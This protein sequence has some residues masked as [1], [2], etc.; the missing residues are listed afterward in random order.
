MTIRFQLLSKENK[1]VP[2]YI[3]FRV[4][5]SKEL[6]ARTGLYV[7]PKDWNDKKRRAFSRNPLLKNLN[8]DLDQIA[9]NVLRNTPKSKIELEDLLRGKSVLRTGVV[10]LLNEMIEET[11]KNKWKHSTLRNYKVFYNLLKEYNGFSTFDKID[12]SKIDAFVSWLLNTKKYSK[13]YSG[14]QLTRLK[15]ICREARILGISTHPYCTDFKSFNQPKS[16]R[17]I[18]TLSHDEVNSLIE[19]SLENKRLE[20][21][22]KWLVLGLHLGFRVNDLLKTTKRNYRHLNDLIVCD[23]IQQKTGNPVTVPILNK[24]VLEI[25]D[26]YPKPIT[27]V[28]FNRTIKKVCKFAG[29]T[30]EIVGDL[31]NNKT[32]RKERGVYPKYKLISSH[33]MRRTFAT[34]NYNKVPVD[35]LMEITGHSKESMLLHYINKTKTKDEKAIQFARS[36][37]S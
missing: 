30:D 6:R 3:R 36:L 37:Q 15:T 31:Y 23:I 18:T 19:L 29:I 5:N 9:S 10:E 24:K 14:R 8:A 26:V 4:P 17:L 27:D 25:L 33:A 22:R 16:E 7:N 28:E 11:Y 12:K 1:P 13:S 20:N 32:Q 35:I 34:L 2:I 21:A